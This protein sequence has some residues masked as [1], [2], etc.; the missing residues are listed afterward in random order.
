MHVV[1][2]KEIAITIHRFWLAKNAIHQSGKI[3]REWS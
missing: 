2:D 3:M 1:G